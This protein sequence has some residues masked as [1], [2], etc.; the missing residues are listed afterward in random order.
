MH[1]LKLTKIDDFQTWLFRNNWPELIRSIEQKFL[2]PEEVQNIRDHIGEEAFAKVVRKLDIQK[3]EFET[4]QEVAHQNGTRFRKQIPKWDKIE[5]KITEQVILLSCN[6]T[7]ENTLL[8]LCEGL[9]YLE[10]V[11]AY[12]NGFNKRVQK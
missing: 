5:R 1:H 6:K 11:N 9:T 4:K 3:Q 2:G 12:Q 8:L 10:F 7:Q